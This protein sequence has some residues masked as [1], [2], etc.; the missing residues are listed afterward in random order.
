MQH[1][2]RCIPGAF[3]DVAYEDL[4]TNPAGESRRILDY[5][6]L[7]WEDGCLEFHNLASASATASAA[8]VRR[9][10]YRSSVGKW[11]CYERQLA[12]FCHQLRAR[13]VQFSS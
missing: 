11:K 8:Q 6:G 4:V 1:W 5:L 3:L 12:P 13:G 10:I 7:E 2:R 9:P